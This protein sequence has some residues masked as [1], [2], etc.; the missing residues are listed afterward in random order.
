MR[1]LQKKAAMRSKRKACPAPLEQEKPLLERKNVPSRA[2]AEPVPFGRTLER[3]VVQENLSRSS[4]AGHEIPRT[5]K[6]QRPLDTLDMAHV[7]TCT[8]TPPE[9]PTA[10]ESDVATDPCSQWCAVRLSSAHRHLKSGR[11]EHQ[12]NFQ[13]KRDVEKLISIL[14][15]I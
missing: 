15:Q 11:S 12:R 4:V 1:S 13:L 2:S 14:M 6:D 5:S 7:C 10:E 8:L 9:R 3:P